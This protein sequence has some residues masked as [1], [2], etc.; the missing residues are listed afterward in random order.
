[1]TPSLVL[2]STYSGIRNFLYF[3]SIYIR[4]AIQADGI[5]VSRD[6]AFERIGEVRR[7]CL[8]SL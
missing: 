7:I 4:V 3:D 2:T 5:I 6:A 1:M 8:E